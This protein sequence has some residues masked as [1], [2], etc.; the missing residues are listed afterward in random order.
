LP[1]NADRTDL[2]RT[3]MLVAAACSVAFLLSASAASPLSLRFLPSPEVAGAL[4]LLLEFIATTIAVVVVAVSFQALDRDS[5]HSACTL[6]YAF[7]VVACVGI[8]HTVVFR[9]T[10]VSGES[11]A[12]IDSIYFWLVRRFFETFAFCLIAGALALRRSRIFWVGAALA[13][14]AL[15]AWIAVTGGAWLQGL[16]VPGVGPSRLAHGIDAIFA[17]INLVTALLLWRRGIRLRSRSDLLLAGSSTVLGLASFMLVVA[18]GSVQLPLIMGH[19][20]RVSAYGCLYAAVYLFAI[21]EPHDLLRNSENCLRDSREQ[22]KALGDNLPKG[23]VFQVHATPE[24]LRQFVYVSEGIKWLH[25]LTPAAVMHDSALLYSLIL[26]KDRPDLQAAEMRSYHSMAT[27]NKVVRY[28]LEGGGVGWIQICAQPRKSTDGRVVWDGV[29]IDVTDRER[30]LS[31][32]QEL[33]T[34][35][36]RRVAERTAGLM[37]A[38]RSLET[39]SHLVAH[40]LRAPLRH[41]EGFSSIL[42]AEYAGR[43]DAEG[44]RLLDK[45]VEGAETMNRLIE[46]MLSVARLESASLSRGDTD[47]S[48]LCSSICRTLADADPGRKVSFR[49]Q[50]GIVDCADRILIKNVLENLLGNAW[51]FTSREADARI[52]F[53]AMARDGE[54]VYYVR[55]NGAGFDPRQA[56]KLFTLFHR[57]HPAQEFPGTGVGLASVRSIIANHGGRVWAEG[58]VGKGA[59]LYFTL[60]ASPARLR[61]DAAAEAGGPAGSSQGSMQ[62]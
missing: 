16:R 33:N 58:A 35:L 25:G 45:I 62:H 34:D 11:Q 55:D 41:V 54:R 50:P 17:T 40:D 38:N 32:L 6:I 18:P 23:M 48:A 51:K 20:L 10:P 52:E 4:H 15:F 46:G 29:G 28:R 53:G 2:A 37:Q 14:S 19:V 24:G 57:L 56:D 44:R 47:L 26:E 21:R 49:I 8:A 3:Q 7:S 31:T 9:G 27:F 1:F 12:A 5:R 30:A 36:E 61:P 39:F 60:G 13:T 22:L 59:T 42:K 43:L